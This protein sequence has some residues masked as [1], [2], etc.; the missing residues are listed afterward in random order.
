MKQ[1]LTALAL[2]SLTA[3]AIGWAFLQQQTSELEECQRNL[4]ELRRQME[5]Y[6]TDWQGAEPRDLTL[7]TPNYLRTLPT[8]P[9]NEAATYDLEHGKVPW[10]FTIICRGEHQAHYRA[11]PGC[12][13][14]VDPYR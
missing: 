12:S 5:M 8:C 2:S 10:D 11:L 1:V 4:A 3:L 9:T 13:L 6:S 7:L 14:G